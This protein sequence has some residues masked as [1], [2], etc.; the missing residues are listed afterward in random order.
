MQ[1]QLSFRQANCSSFI[2]NA[3]WISIAL[4]CLATLLRNE[5]MGKLTGGFEWNNRQC[6]WTEGF[7]GKKSLN[8]LLII[9]C[10]ATPNLHSIF[11]QYKGNPH[12]CAWYNQNHQADF[13]RCLA[14]VLSG[15]TQNLCNPN[16]VVC[17]RCPDVVFEQ[18]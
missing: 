6:T 7:V 11:C 17:D 4:V 15:D 2:M 18:Y 14:N 12:S 1:P 3:K 16:T 13:Y 9:Q 5:A 10:K 8:R